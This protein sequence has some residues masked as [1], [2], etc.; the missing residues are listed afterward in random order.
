M[1]APCCFIC[2]KPFITNPGGG[3]TTHLDEHGM[4]DYEEDAN[5]TPFVME[6][7]LLPEEIL[8]EIQDEDIITDSDAGSDGVCTVADHGGG[9]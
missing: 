5:H 1:S 2:D 3:T 9:F 6:D 8:E 4:V 7:L